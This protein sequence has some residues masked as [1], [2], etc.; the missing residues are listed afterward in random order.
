MATKDELIAQTQAA[1][2]G[3]QLDAIGAQSN[4][5]DVQAAVQSRRDQL[6]PAAATARATSNQPVGPEA[7]T[8]RDKRQYFEVSNGDGTWRQVNAWGEE[9]GSSEDKKRSD[10]ASSAA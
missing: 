2:T 9:K 8:E 3:E 10:K 1:T 6:A 5:S 4:D 7:T